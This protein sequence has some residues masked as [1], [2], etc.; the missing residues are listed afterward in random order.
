[1]K[2]MHEDEEKLFSGIMKCPLCHDCENYVVESDLQV[3][4]FTNLLQLLYFLGEID[5]YSLKISLI[6]GISIPSKKV[7][8]VILL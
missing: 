5:E 2:K 7:S 6:S 4:F 3:N 8:N 1:M